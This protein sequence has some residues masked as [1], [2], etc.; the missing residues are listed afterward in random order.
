MIAPQRGGHHAQVE[1]AVVAPTRPRGI[2]SYF[3]PVR[4]LPKKPFRNLLR[5]SA[6]VIRAQNAVGVLALKRF[7]ARGDLGLEEIRE[8]RKWLRGRWQVSL[9]A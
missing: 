9:S 5:S 2:D 4:F 6:P 3:G 8:K 1:P 7:G